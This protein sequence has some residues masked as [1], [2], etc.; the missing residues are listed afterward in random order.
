MLPPMP[1]PPPPSAPSPRAWDDPR[2]R[3]AVYLTAAVFVA[4]CV[5]FAALPVYKGF[6]QPFNNKDYGLWYLTGQKVLNGEPIYPDEPGA[7]FP[8]MYPPFAAVG[9]YAPLSTLGPGLMTVALV[10]I[11]SAAWLGCLFLAVYL[12]SGRLL[13]RELLLYIIPGV[14]TAPYVWDTFFLGQINIVLLLL[15]LLCFTALRH[16]R[17]GWAGAALAVAVAI[18]AFPLMA[19]GYLVWRR[20]WVALGSLAGTLI[21]ILVLMPAPIRGFSFNLH[22]LNLWVQGMVL[23]DSTEGISQRPGIAYTY[24][25]QSLLAMTHRYLRDV[26]AGETEAVV[27]GGERGYWYVNL[28]DVGRVPANVIFVALAGGLCLMYVLVMPPKRRLTPRLMVY[29][30]AMLLILI[31]LFSPLAW[32]YFF[33]WLML[34][35]AAV[36]HF[37]HESPKGSAREVTGMALLGGCVL[38]LASALTQ[39]FGDQTTQGLGATTWGGL[40]LFF[41][42]AWMLSVTREEALGARA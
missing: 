12:A 23:K 2:H 1:D 25:N 29:E 37:I 27:E 24:R 34:P 36:T 26:P 8:F 39:A 11:N 10:L 15:M 38:I 9:V 28:I 4:V 35:I 30:Q 13:H 5:G 14:V 17:E 40:A 31:V 19:V 3:L 16:G 22:E 33:C 18:K 42:L 32:T 41:T 21:L 7:T 20:H 6:A